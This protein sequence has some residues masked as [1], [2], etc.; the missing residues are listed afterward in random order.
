M[1]RFTI[2]NIKTPFYNY[3]YYSTPKLII[4]QVSYYKIRLTVIKLAIQQVYIGSKQPIPTPHTLQPQA[5]FRRQKLP[6]FA[7]RSF[8]IAHFWQNLLTFY[9]ISDIYISFC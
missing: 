1:I 3:V 9:T 4:C 5:D 7:Y 6:A 2:H 8:H